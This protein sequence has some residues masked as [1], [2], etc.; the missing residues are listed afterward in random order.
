MALRWPK[1][2][3]RSDGPLIGD[4]DR[5]HAQYPGDAFSLPFPDFPP[6]ATFCYPVHNVISLSTIQEVSSHYLK[7]LVCNNLSDL[8]TRIEKNLVLA[9]SRIDT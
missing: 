2:E 1:L 5:I 7:L 4:P 9:T 6:V 8:Y 3:L